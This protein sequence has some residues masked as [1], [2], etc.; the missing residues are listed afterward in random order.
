MDEKRRAGRL[1]KDNEITITIISGVKKSPKEKIIYHI[2]KDISVYG[3][4]I[5]VNSF[6]PV[7]T[8]L[9]IDITLKNPHQ[10]ITAF[11]KVKWIKS[12]FADESYEAGLEFVHTSSDTIQQLAD[13]ISEKQK[14]EKS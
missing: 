5:N 1:K 13:Y 6:L 12:L 10:M 7:D 4:R 3:A 9:K 14:F 11:G 2:S 8:L